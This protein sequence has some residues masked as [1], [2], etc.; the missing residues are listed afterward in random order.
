V[1]RGGAIL[2]T[3]I[4]IVHCIR[5][6]R[7]PGMALLLVVTMGVLASVPFLYD[8]APRAYAA[9]ISV[10][11]AFIGIGSTAIGAWMGK[12]NIAAKAVHG[13]PVTALA[14]TFILTT[15]CAPTAWLYAG[16]AA[17]ERAFDPPPTCSGG[18]VAAIVAPGLEA[19]L[20]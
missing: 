11:A 8:G 14:M 16:T 20:S 12:S 19:L 9:T 5:R 1:L 7:D 2:L 3:L 4:G 17:A 13:P 18:E 15:L 10:T 6:R